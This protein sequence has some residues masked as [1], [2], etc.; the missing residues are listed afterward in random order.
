MIA[1][2]NPNFAQPKLKILNIFDKPFEGGVVG[3]LSLVDLGLAERQLL[4]GGVGEE[5]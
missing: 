1:W 3:V 5:S 4:E 2:A